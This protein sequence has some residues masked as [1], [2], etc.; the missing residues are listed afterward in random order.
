[1]RACSNRASMRGMTLVEL[2]IALGISCVLMVVGFSLQLGTMQVFKYTE[3]FTSLSQDSFLITQWLRGAVMGA[4]GGAMQA[5]MGVGV[6]DNCA[7]LNGMPACQNSDRLTI[8]TT[9][10]PEQQCLIKGQVGAIVSHMPVILQ[11]ATPTPGTCCLTPGPGQLDFSKQQIMLVN[12]GIYAER[13]VTKV[14]IPNCQLTYQDGQAARFDPATF[15]TDWSGGT[16]NLVNVRTLYWD[17]AANTLNSYTEADGDN[18][19]SDAETTVLADQIYDFQVALGYDFNPPDGQVSQSA[20]GTKDEWL[21]NAVGEKP[22]VGFFVSPP[23]TSASLMLMQIG[24]LVG[25]VKANTTYAQTLPLLNG[26]GKAVPNVNLRPVL[27]K[28]APRNTTLF[29]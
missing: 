27:V 10:L 9:S 17:P 3:D 14:D 22:G 12:N 19:R 25:A 2:L 20:D 7:A 13:A 24:V 1:M 29:Q 5:W 16:V 6:E 21:Y 4:G 23:F 15:V 11:I 18:A 8:T 26:P 28:M